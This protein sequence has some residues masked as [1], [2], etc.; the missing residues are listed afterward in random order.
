MFSGK[1][2]NKIE[3]YFIRHSWL[4]E[5]EAAMFETVY[6]KTKLC[7][8]KYPEFKKPRKEWI[9]AGYPCQSVITDDQIKWAIFVEQA[10]DSIAQGGKLNDFLDYMGT[11]II[12]L[13]QLV[14][15]KVAPLK[16]SLVERLIIIN[17]H[18]REVVRDMI[19][20]DVKFKGDFEWLNFIGKKISMFKQEMNEWKSSLSKQIQDLFMVMNI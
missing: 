8:E 14:R 18:A 9:Y 17:V 6:D 12:E 4:N 5:L 11:L 13:S 19:K 7:L 1:R 3:S 10:I 20:K 2:D 15:E 16:K